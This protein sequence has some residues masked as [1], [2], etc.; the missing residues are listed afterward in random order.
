[1]ADYQLPRS[2]TSTVVKTSPEFNALVDQIRQQ[3]F[4]P[5]YRRHAREF[6][7][8]H[9]NSF[10]TLTELECHPVAANPGG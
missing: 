5:T 8:R 4:D 6:N 7:L 1:M 2:A 10:Q 3:G 9:P